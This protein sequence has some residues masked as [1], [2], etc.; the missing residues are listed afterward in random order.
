[1]QGR[2]GSATGLRRARPQVGYA[3]KYTVPIKEQRMS[4]PIYKLRTELIN[5]INDHQVRKPPCRPRS[6]AVGAKLAQNTSA[7]Y[8]CIPA[9]MRGPACIFWARLTQLSLGSSSL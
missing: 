8:R 9:G 6:W 4:L 1:M 7:V 3:R 5:A 2:R